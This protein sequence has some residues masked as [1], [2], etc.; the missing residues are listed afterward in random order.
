MINQDQDQNQNQ[1][2][3]MQAKIDL[4]MQKMELLFQS[5]KKVYYKAPP[6]LETRGPKK[7]MSNLLGEIEVYITY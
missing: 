5:H 6:W 2:Q 1:D 3:E 4:E 7:V